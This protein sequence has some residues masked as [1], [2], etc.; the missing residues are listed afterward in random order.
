MK[1][2]ERNDQLKF[3]L[4]ILNHPELL[5]EEYVREWLTHEENKSVYEECRLYLEAGLRKEVGER[6]DV[7][8]EY[9]RFNRKFMHRPGRGVFHY[10]I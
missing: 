2:D 5:Q 7:T 1:A 4:D 10:L 9:E 3:A 6:L 8:T